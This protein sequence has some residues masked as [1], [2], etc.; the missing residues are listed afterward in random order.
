MN[1]NGGQAFLFA[2][3]A[4]F[5]QLTEAHG[6]HEAA[7][8]AGRHADSMRSLA[9]EYEAELVNVIG[10]AVMMRVPDAKDAVK[11]AVRIVD[12]VGAQHGIPAIRVGID[13][14]SAVERDGDY[15]GRAVNTA[16]R[17]TELAG[18]GEVLLTDAVRT[19]AGDIGGFEISSRGNHALKG[20][21][22]TVGVFHAVRSGTDSEESLP[23]DPVCKMAV[24][25]DER[26]GTVEH[27]G[28]SY[29]FCSPDCK[30][31]FTDSPESFVS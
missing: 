9:R 27:N 1:D 10:D 8:Q 23:I 29:S 11:V 15:F 19:A 16:A 26:A 2:D 13:F 7:D 12:E 20:V 28:V 30:D 21:R 6:D 5:T 4:G 31:K 24:D 17:V 22:D 25:P 3:L 18:A 14:G